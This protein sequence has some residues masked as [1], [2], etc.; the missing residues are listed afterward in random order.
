MPVEDGAQSRFRVAGQYGS[1]G[2]AAVMDRPAAT[3]RDIEIEPDLWFD[4][5]RHRRVS[6]T[7]GSDRA[8]GARPAQ[9]SALD[10]S[11]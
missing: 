5:P 7:E 10:S 6:P 11:L 2:R 4:P 1:G 3:D 8:S 9:T